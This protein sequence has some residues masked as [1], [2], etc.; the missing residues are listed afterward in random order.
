[1]YVRKG[2]HCQNSFKTW[3]LG[4]KSKGGLISVALRTLLEKK[5]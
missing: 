2:F 4:P 3:L 5:T 1:M